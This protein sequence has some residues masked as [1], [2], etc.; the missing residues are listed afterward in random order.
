MMARKLKREGACKMDIDILELSER[1]ARFILSGVSVSFANALRRS[2]LAE[3]PVMAIDEI[4]IYD[5][6]SVLF[7]EQLALR[8]GLIPLKADTKDFSLPEECTCEG[9]GCPACQVS[10]TLSAEGPKIV[11]SGDIVSSDPGVCPAD[12]TI[13]IVELKEKH[14]VVL[15]AIARLGTYRK[16][17]KWQAGIVSGYKSVPV[18]TFRECDLCGECVEVCPRDILKIEGNK[19]MITD[20]GIIECSLC[21]L[22]EEGCDMDAISV[23][24]DPESCVM[25]FETSGGIT[26]AKLAVEAANSIKTRAQKMGEILD[27]L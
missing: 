5:N 22:C 21:K 27:T 25:M 7:D 2:I 20:K 24:Y 16:H 15:E 11:N 4:N 8:M 26:A 1:K 13:P 23:G 9:K 10:M 14:K 17:A 6:T 18:L 3:V 19:V 12:A